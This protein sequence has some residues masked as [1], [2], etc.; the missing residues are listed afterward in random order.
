MAVQF[1]GKEPARFRRG[2]TELAQI[3]ER[4]ASFK[5][6]LGFPQAFTSYADDRFG[7]RRMFLHLGSRLRWILGLKISPTVLFG[8]NGWLYLGKHDN[9]IEQFRGIDVFSRDELVSWVQRMVS[10]RDWLRER[11]IPFILVVAP[12]KHTI[13]PEYLPIRV[14]KSWERRHLINWRNILP[15]HTDLDFVDLRQPL[16]AAKKEYRVFYKTDSHWNEMGGF[17]GYRAI[18][19][20]V[21]KYFPHVKALQLDQFS[22]EERLMPTGDLAGMINLQGKMVETSGFLVPKF[23]SRILRN[24]SAAQGKSSRRVDILSNLDEN[25]NVL[26]FSDSFIIGMMKYLAETFRRTVMVPHNGLAFDT[27]LINAEK[28]DWSFTKWLNGGLERDP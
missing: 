7:L 27:A 9:V 13:Y 18:M 17:A 15:R 11:G 8:K 10:R 22:I 19:A 1:T 16:M 24:T 3:P 25:P 5:E 14:G 20:H 21:K 2:K 6:V 23:K 12:N 4:P 28:P 26:I